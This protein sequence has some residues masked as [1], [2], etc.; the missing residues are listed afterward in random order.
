MVSALPVALCSL[1]LTSVVPALGTDAQEPDSATVDV[2]LRLERNWERAIA[3]NDQSMI[4]QTVASDYVYVSL[5][6]Q[7][8]NRAQAQAEKLSR[9]K[10]MTATVKEIRVRTFGTSAV[11][12]GLT[13][14]VS[15][16]KES[17]VIDQYRWSHVFVRRDNAWQVVSEQWTMVN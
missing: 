3:S 15:K 2:I 4:E 11:V 14:E 5:T 17:P 16:G 10:S 12:V 1:F 13:R 6:G 7:I 9:L 8:L